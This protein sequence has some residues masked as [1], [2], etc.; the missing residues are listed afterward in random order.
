VM[1]IYVGPLMVWSSLAGGIPFAV[2]I[3]LH[4]LVFI[5]GTA[6]VIQRHIP[7]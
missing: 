1:L 6:S 2:V 3:A 4:A 5:A 7:A